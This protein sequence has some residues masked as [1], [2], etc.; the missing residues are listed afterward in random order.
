MLKAAAGGGGKGMRLVDSEGDDPRRGAVAR[1]TRRRARSA[2]TASTSRRFVD[3]PRHVEIQ[4]LGDKHGNVVHVYERECSIQRRHQKVIEE[5]PSPALDP[6]TREAMG[7]VAVQAAKAVDYVGAGTIEFLV[8]SKRNFYFLEMN[9][10][11]QVEHPITE[12]VTGVDLVRTA[13]RGRGRRTAAL[14]ARRHPPAR[15]GHGM[16]RLCRG[17]REQLFAGARQDQPPARAGRARG[18]QRHRGLRRVR[19]EHL[20]RPD[21]LEAR[22]LGRD[23]RGSD[24]RAWS[25]PSAST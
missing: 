15:L 5:S 13:D 7:E 24:R 2:T 6:K 3:S 16:P 17:S 4:V 9:T 11:L 8:D 23:A 21:D 18:T 22:R 14:P 12:M 10:R 25:A 19:G 20:L 1:G